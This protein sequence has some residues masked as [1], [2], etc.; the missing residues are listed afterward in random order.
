MNINSITD[1]QVSLKG[2]SWKYYEV[3]KNISNNLAEIFNINSIIATIV[4]K[5]VNNKED[6]NNFL[7][8]TLRNNL[9][10]VL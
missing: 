2:Q 3:D 10:E 6:Y 9:P 4:A 8:P 1:E 5:R 7:N